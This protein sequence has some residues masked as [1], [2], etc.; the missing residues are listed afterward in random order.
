MF[1]KYVEAAMARAHYEIMEDGDFWG[2]IPGFQGVWGTG[3]TLDGCR[4][5]LQS[6]LES[7]LVLGLWLNHTDMPVLGRLSII[8][9]GPRKVAKRSSGATTDAARNRKAS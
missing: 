9:R 5:H 8:P 7:W 2:E 1:T 4:D 3:K 6:V